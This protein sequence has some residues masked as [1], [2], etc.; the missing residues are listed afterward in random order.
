MYIRDQALVW[1][2]SYIRVK[3]PISRH[4]DISNKQL[5]ILH[6]DEDLLVIVKPHEFLSVPGKVELDSVYT[7]IQEMFPSITGPIIVHRLD[8][9]TSGIM[10]LAKNKEAH[11]ALQA[12]DSHT[13]AGGRRPAR[14]ESLSP[15]PARGQGPDQR[16]QDPW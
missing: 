2:R 1:G 12:E 7:R 9:A 3:T 16:N 15:D 5:Q 11:R 8:M 10:L 6:E 4:P 13:L 14:P